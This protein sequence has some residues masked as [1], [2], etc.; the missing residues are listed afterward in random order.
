M[1]GYYGYPIHKPQITDH[2]A[3]SAIPISTCLI[4]AHTRMTT[5]NS[6]HTM[7]KAQNQFTKLVVIQ[8]YLRRKQKPLK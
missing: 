6:F 1:D 5:N 7:A 2:W 4:T 8:L 3:G